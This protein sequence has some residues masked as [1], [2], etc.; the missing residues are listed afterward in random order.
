[1][2]NP[3]EVAELALAC[4]HD[5]VERLIALIGS[6]EA[7]ADGRAAPELAL[8]EMTRADEDNK[9]ARD[10]W[11]GHAALDLLMAA[12]EAIAPTGESKPNH[13]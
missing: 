13:R 12:R 10:Q 5:S 4:A 9:P 6:N 8:I 1:M 2:Q 3:N 7:W 11:T